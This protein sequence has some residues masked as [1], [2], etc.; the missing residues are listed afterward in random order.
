MARSSRAAKQVNNIPA[1]DLQ[2]MLGQD[3][4]NAIRTG[5]NQYLAD[6]GL[7]IVQ[8][9]MQG[10]VD[11]LCGLMNSR[12]TQGEAVR[13][14]TQQGVVQ[15][16]GAKEHIQRPR[17]RTKD[18]K[19]EIDLETYSAFN[20]KSVLSQEMLVAVG[21]GVS[22]RQYQSIV[23]KQLRKHGVSRSAVSRR[24]IEQS[25]H[26]LEV[27]RARR[28]E[29]NNFV[30]LLLDGVRI[31]KQM[32]IA[33]V[34]VDRSGYK[35]VL[36]WRIG[37]TENEVVCRDL[38]RQLIDA[39]LKPD[40]DYLFV[41]DGSK[42]LLQ[43]IRSAFGINSQIQRCQEHKIRDV[44]GYL[45]FKYRA[46]FRSKLQTAFN[47]TTY[48]KAS[49][50]LQKVRSELLNISASAAT[51]LTEGLEHTLTLHRLSIHGGVRDS[52]RTTNIIESAF[53]RLRQHT[54]NVNSWS[55]AEQV[56]RWL[57]LGLAKVEKGFR[58]LAGYRQ[59]AKLNK[60]VKEHTALQNPNS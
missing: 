27:F 7:A 17:V 49:D 12:K 60:K 26:A 30:A 38:I 9:L 42:A 48:K 32:V 55:D 40:N 57:A 13:W 5:V 29:R 15:V 22:T 31:G 39:G 45:P 33:A 56:N 8:A 41:I 44:E 23:S 19:H 11:N 36:G 18:G 46:S 37:S 34:G 43:A 16:R 50:R 47:E 59:L 24:V 6:L 58:R 20:K 53:S 51:S 3:F 1:Q 54:R 35:H 4:E 14:G 21:A 25:T 10:E 52:L 2:A 28:W